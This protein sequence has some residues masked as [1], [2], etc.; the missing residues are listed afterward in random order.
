MCKGNLIHPNYVFLFHQTMVLMYIIYYMDLMSM[1]HRLASVCMCTTVYIPPSSAP[2]ILDTPRP[3][4]SYHKRGS[5]ASIDTISEWIC[6]I[7]THLIFLHIL[8]K[9]YFI[10]I[11]TWD[12][13]LIQSL[14][15]LRSDFVQGGIQIIQLSLC[16]LWD[17]L[18]VCLSFS[19]LFI[20]ILQLPGMSS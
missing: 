6:R 1:L 4:D 5:E 16:L 12:V 13:L 11:L 10:N 19:W 17:H 9:W 2:L 14:E 20:A 8:W 18:F 3:E 15:H 7:A